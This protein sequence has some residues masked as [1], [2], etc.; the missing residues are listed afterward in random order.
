MTAASAAPAERLDAL[1]LPN[2]AMLVEDGGS[3]ATGLG[4]WAA[5]RLTDG[6]DDHGWCSPEGKPTG[7]S[8]VWELDTTWRLDTLALSTR[9]LQESGYPGIAV[10]TVELLVSGDT[11]AWKSVGQFTIGKEERREF[12]LPRG[13][14]ASRVKLVV[15]A[16]HGNAQYTEIAEVDLFGDRVKPT[17]TRNI[18]GDYSTTYGPLRFVQD[19]EDLYGCYDWRPGSL[20]WG[21]IRGRVAQVTWY[22][23]RKDHADQGP[24]TFAVTSGGALW[25]V[26]YSDSGAL[27]GVWNGP[28]VPP[29]QG[30]TCQPARKPRIAESLRKDG[31]VV[32]YGI[33]FATG[34]D[35]PLPESSHTLEQ[36]LAALQGERDLRVEIAG[37]TDATAGDAF[38]LDL[39]NRRASSVMA[40]LVKKGIDGKRLTA[41]G[42]GRT[43]PTADNG[44]EQGRGLNRRVEVTVVK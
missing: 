33:R 37:H 32:L 15:I 20:L 8:F 40:W 3:Y 10:K 19:G 13:A 2:G 4:D 18:A 42:Y 43:R 24:A 41:K 7:L 34:S 39:S 12:P 1:D 9:N 23:P 28:R 16:N 25:G 38:N 5:W 44:T 6:S 30:P 35:A 22:E 36:L 11:G 14:Q 29:A 17:P 26:W 21:T 27:G 31:R